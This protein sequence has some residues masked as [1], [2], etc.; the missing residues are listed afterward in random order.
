MTVHSGARS[1]A[2]PAGLDREQLLEMYYYMRL[3]RSLEER[4]VNL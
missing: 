2:I 3:T 4:L 1:H